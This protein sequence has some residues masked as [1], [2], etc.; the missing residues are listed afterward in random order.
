MPN[1]AASFPGALDIAVGVLR[2]SQGRI[3]IAQRRPGTPAAGKWEFPGGKHEPGETLEATLDRELAEEIGVTCR[4][5]R[6]LIRISHDYSAPRVRL[7][8]W[9]VSDWAGEVHGREGQRL[10]WCA[11]DELARYDLLAANTAIVHALVLPALLAIT[12]DCPHA[13]QGPWL[14]A[15]DATLASGVDLLRLRA[16]TLDDAA[17]E[18]L[19]Q[20]VLAR[21]KRTQVLLDRDAAMAERMGAAGLY[22]TAARAAS[23]P[24]RPIARDYWFGVSAHDAGELHTAMA[25]DADF[26]VL[27]PVAAT[28]THPGRPP[29]GWGGWQCERGE[30]GLPVYALGGMSARDLDTARAHNAQGI[31]GIR[32]FWKTTGFKSKRRSA[33][34]PRR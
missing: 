27:S 24:G 32:G 19:A 29:L 9:L 31:A 33:A 16:P 13:D 15:L 5:S 12:P 17:Y 1:I 2:D 22:W 6:P 21:A 3:L 30:L 11:P 23:A 25:V 20:R 10:V 18:A 8:V 14:T 7:H 26:A 34:V 28:A 4:A